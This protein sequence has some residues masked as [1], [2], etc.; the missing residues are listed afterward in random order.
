VETTET[1][2]QQCS[3]LSQE[4]VVYFEW[5]R[6][7]LTSQNAALIDQAVANIA[8]R[9][10]CSAGSVTIVG[11]TDSSGGNAYNEALSVRRA[12][13]VAA[14]LTERGIAASAITKAARGETE[15]AKATNDGVRE[16]LNRRSEVTI[17]VQ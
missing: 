11:H 4:F 14:A 7:D 5:D 10:E 8:S 13:V 17:I 2:Q 9:A 12:D 1:V 6:S 3:A 15:L 16:P